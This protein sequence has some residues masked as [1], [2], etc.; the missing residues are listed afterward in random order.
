M[1][2]LFISQP[3]R[4]KTPA[5]ILDERSR[6]IFQAEKMFPDGIEVLDTYYKDFDGNRVEFLGRSIGDLGKADV[7]IFAPGWEEYTGCRCEHTVCEEYGITHI[8]YT[9][10]SGMDQE[11]EAAI[12]EGA[13]SHFGYDAQMVKAIEELGELTVELARHRNGADNFD[14]VR[15]ELADAFV[16]LNQMEL[17]FG[18]VTEIEAAKLERLARMIGDVSV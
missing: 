12:L 18:D 16:M 11:R 5:E 6:M 10:R 3:M 8:H 15:E 13:L 17:I 14:A 7:A 2:K 9:P 4:G 1:K